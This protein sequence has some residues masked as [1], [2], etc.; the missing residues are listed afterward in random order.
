MEIL[1][2]NLLHHPQETVLVFRD[3]ESMIYCVKVIKS[4]FQLIPNSGSR[5]S[6]I[7][8]DHTYLSTIAIKK[9]VTFLLTAPSV[10]EVFIMTL[11][12]SFLLKAFGTF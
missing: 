10:L 12:A 2:A 3:R 9:P 8:K 4:K 1:Q 7:R 6:V 11:G 5:N